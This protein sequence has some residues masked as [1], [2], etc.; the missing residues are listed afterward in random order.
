MVFNLLKR[1]NNAADAP[2][3][4]EKIE[5]ISNPTGRMFPRLR[6]DFLLAIR[7]TEKSGIPVK[8]S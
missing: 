5:R 6:E 3:G 8:S 4:M 2:A 7:G 1:L